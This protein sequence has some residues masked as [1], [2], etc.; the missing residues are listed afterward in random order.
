VDIPNPRQTIQ[1]F[2]SAT[3]NAPQAFQRLGDAARSAPQTITETAKDTWGKRVFRVALVLAAMFLLLALICGPWTYYLGARRSKAPVVPILLSA[4]TIIPLLVI[5]VRCVARS[6][7]RSDHQPSRFLQ[8]RLLKSV[9][10]GL[11]LGVTYDLTSLD[12][13]GSESVSVQFVAWG[14]CVGLACSLAQSLGNEFDIG[15]TWRLFAPAIGLAVVIPFALIYESG[16]FRGFGA[17]VCWLA[18]GGVGWVVG[19]FLLSKA[20]AKFAGI[21]SYLDKIRWPLFGAVVGY[22]CV[23]LIFGGIYAGLGALPGQLSLAAE[24]KD[25]KDAEVCNPMFASSHGC[26]S[27][28]SLVFYS[29]S[30]ATPL[31]ISDIHPASDWAK[32]AVTIEALASIVWTVVIFAIVVGIANQESATRASQARR[33]AG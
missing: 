26:P 31:A 32:A 3:R 25:A 27:Y 28:V 13:G 14:I 15:R 22:V 16:Y 21:W 7:E 29:A 1:Q 9:A 19:Y 11:V 8:D 6:I 24:S 5:T 23:I 20:L 33:G 4:L 18:G 30:N 12:L 2:G 10:A 17:T